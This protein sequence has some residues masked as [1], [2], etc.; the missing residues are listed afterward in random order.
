MIFILKKIL[1]GIWINKYFRDKIITPKIQK[2]RD[3]YVKNMI[4]AWNK[5]IELC[6]SWDMDCDEGKY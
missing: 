6:Q 5:N 1:S 3:E 4:E 2:M